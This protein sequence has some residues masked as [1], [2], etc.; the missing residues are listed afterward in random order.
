MDKIKTGELIKNAR[1]GKNYTQTELGDLV[2]VSNKAVSR[3][4]NGDSFPDVALLETLANVLDLKIED[5]VLGEVS[6]KRSEDVVSEI[7]RTAKIQRQQRR[8]E[9]RE[10]YYDAAFVVF[11]VFTAFTGIFHELIFFSDASLPFYRISL[12]LSF[13]VLFAKGYKTKEALFDKGNKWVRYG[14]LGLTVLTVYISVL[15]FLSI[16]MAEQ[17]KIIYDMEIHELGPF[18]DHQLMAIG[19]IGFG[20]ALTFM[21]RRYKYEENTIGGI[22]ITIAF[23]HLCIFYISWLYRMTT[24][25]DAY[26][27]LFEHM[28]FGFGGLILV[29]LL[30]AKANSLIKS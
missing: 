9:I 24:P 1:I 26:R 2:G 16:R 7:V 25:A 22:Y 11:L 30:H 18:L 12:I 29:M 27:M 15:L 4:E 23:M 28:L 19:L 3:W 10:K 13:C 5:I 6:S 17:G 20:L 14:C 8:K 21:Y